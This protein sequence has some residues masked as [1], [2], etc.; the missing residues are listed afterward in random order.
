MPGGT[1]APPLAYD[2]PC[3]PGVVPSQIAWLAPKRIELIERF[4]AIAYEPGTS[5][6]ESPPSVER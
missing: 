2:W 6:Q 3:E 4:W 1:T 5:V